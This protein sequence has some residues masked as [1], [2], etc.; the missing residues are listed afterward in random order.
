M[1]GEVCAAVGGGVYSEEMGVGS[2]L[3]VHHTF[4]TFF[5]LTVSVFGSQSQT[6]T[7]VYALTA[8]LMCV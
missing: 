2:K 1:T 3:L 5:S 7:T 6:C 8:H 4:G